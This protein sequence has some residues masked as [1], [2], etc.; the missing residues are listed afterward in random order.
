MTLRLLLSAS[1]IGL[2]GCADLPKDPEGTLDRIRSERVFRVG[3]ISPGG[4]AAERGRQRLLIEGIANAA[5][6]RP[7]LRSG[8]S[9]ELLHQLEEGAVDIVIGPLAQ[10]SPWSKRVTLL[11]PLE[12]KAKSESKS[13][14]KPHAAARNGENAWISLLYREAKAVSKGG[15]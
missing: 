7:E 14:P 9:E 3:I 11:P 4:D 13:A 1:A 12:P 8:A 2:A 10:D 15:S 5:G 6:A